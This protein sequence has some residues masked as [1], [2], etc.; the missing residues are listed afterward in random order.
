MK[1]AKPDVKDA[2]GD[3]TENGMRSARVGLE[4]QR[5]RHLAVT[6][7]GCRR[8]EGAIR[9]LGRASLLHPAAGQAAETRGFPMALAAL[10]LRVSTLGVDDGILGFLLVTWRSRSAP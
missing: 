6:S 9:K 7:P 10:T 5:W 1:Q 4:A 3:D 8:L 2:L